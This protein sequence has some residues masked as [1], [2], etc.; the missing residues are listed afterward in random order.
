MI[1]LTQPDKFQRLSIITLN[2]FMNQQILIS[3]KT[4]TGKT[5]GIHAQPSD[6]ISNIK[7]KILDAEGIPGDQQRLIFNG[8]ELHDERTLSDHNIVNESSLH[9]LISSRIGD[10]KINNK[11]TVKTL[12]GK[13][14][15]FDFNP[16]DTVSKLKA[17]IQDKEGFHQDDQRLVFR[18]LQ[19]ENERTLSD[20]NIYPDSIIHL[21]LRLKAGDQIIFVKTSEGKTLQFDFVPQDT[22]ENFKLKI[23]EKVGCLPEDQKLIFAGRALENGKTLHDYNIQ[24][25]STINLVVNEPKQVQVEDEGVAGLFG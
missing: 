9:L 16:Q 21:V 13:S 3:I 24:N 23:Q 8:I 10:E 2:K 17:K 20:Y 14:I 19:L 11:F 1:H 15:E 5:F 12:T 6:T 7:A 18:G 22:V 25:E 4:L